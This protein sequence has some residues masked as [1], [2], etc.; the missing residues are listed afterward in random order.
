[1]DQSYSADSLNSFSSQSVLE[2]ELRQAQC[3]IKQQ[4]AKI[5]ELEADFNERIALL[6]KQRDED[7]DWSGRQLA[8]A[9][10][11]I[12]QLEK[13]HESTEETTRQLNKLAIELDRRNRAGQMGVTYAEAGNILG[14]GKS[15]ICQLRTLIASDSRFN[16][17]WHPR[18]ANMKII[19]LKRYSKR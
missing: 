19:E 14:V 11:R 13:T 15:R 6:E 7:L 2:A 10:K 8:E 16:V 4:Q 1:M 5:A 12:S 17:A 9:H 3:Q 18:R